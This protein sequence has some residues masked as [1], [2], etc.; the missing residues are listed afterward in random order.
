MRKILYILIPIFICSISSAQSFTIDK[1]DT[2]NVIDANNLKQGF[3]RIFGKMKKLPEYQPDQVVEEGNYENSRK[4]GMWKNFF[5]NGKIKSEIAYVNSRPNGTYRTYFENGQ[6]EEEGSWENNRNT[7]GFK[8]YHENGQTAQQFVFNESG[9][10][11]G[12][13]VYFYENGQVMI[14]ADIVA[15]KEKFVKEFYED[16][17]VK[18]EKYFNDG[19]IDATKTK[20]YEPKTPIKNKEDKELASSPVKVIKADKNDVVNVGTFNG[21]GQHTMYN[22]DKQLSKVGL[23]ENYRLMDGL[24]YKYDANGILIVIEKY[25]AG[26]YIGDAPLPK[27]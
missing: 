5:P 25:K 21:N 16:G 13:Q 1:G 2:I 24:L 7:G 17:S 3:W 6:V 27:E 12:K 15:G 4:Q 22:K 14:E 9:K 19:E 8:R 10:R 18:A 23:F 11:D 20:V 26:R